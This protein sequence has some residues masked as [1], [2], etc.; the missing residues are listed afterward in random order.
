MAAAISELALYRLLTFQAP[1]LMSLFRCLCRTKISV[2]VR[3]LSVNIRN[4]DMFSRWG[5]V[6][7]SPKPK[8]ENHTLSAVCDYIFYIFAAILHIEGR[9]SIR[10]LRTCH[11]MV[12]GTK[13][14][15]SYVLH[16]VL[17][18]YGC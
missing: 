8:L 13:L 18:F 12:T 5:V 2:Q 4:K 14:S 6:S 9:S 16:L 10:N 15:H 7:P 17:N 11:A 1:N 3:G